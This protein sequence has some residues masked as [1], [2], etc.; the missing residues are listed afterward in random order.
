MLSHSSLQETMYSDTDFLDF[1]TGSHK[2][3]RCHWRENPLSAA[4]SIVQLICFT[5]SPAQN[6]DPVAG[7]TAL[8][9]LPFAFC[10]LLWSAPGFGW[11]QFFQRPPSNSLKKK[12]IITYIKPLSLLSS[13][14]KSSRGRRK[15]GMEVPQIR[16]KK[17][18]SKWWL[19]N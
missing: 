11:K 3:C 8:P 19:G 12:K 16:T 13:R 7:Q 10:A 17:Q 2:L 6:P 14:K 5:I 4:S 9:W 15:G 18:W 1:P